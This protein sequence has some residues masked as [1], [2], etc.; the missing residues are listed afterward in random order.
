MGCSVVVEVCRRCR[1]VVGW[2]SECD[3]LSVAIDDVE[4]ENPFDE[5]VVEVVD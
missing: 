2:S 3:C 1:V 4:N 5:V